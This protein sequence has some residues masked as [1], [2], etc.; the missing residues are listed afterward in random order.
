MTAEALAGRHFAGTLALA[1]AVREAVRISDPDEI[2]LTVRRVFQA[3][4]IAVNEEFSALDGFLRV[5][6]GCLKSGG[7]A[8]LLTFHSGEDRRVKQA[9]KAGISAGVFSEMSDGVITAGPEE[10]RLNPRSSSAK[11]RWVTRA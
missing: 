4:R 11:L 7:R 10:R 6:P 5:L 1:Q 2:E 3:V 9:L 8:A